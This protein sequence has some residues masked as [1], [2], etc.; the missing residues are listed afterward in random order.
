MKDRSLLTVFLVCLISLS[1]SCASDKTSEKA[2]VYNNRGLAKA[3]SGEYEAA[4][5]AYSAA[6]L[7]NPNYAKAYNNRGV[8]K[9]RL[10]RY[11]AAIADMTLQYAWVLTWESPTT[12]VGP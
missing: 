3:K 5:E 11:E 8:A 1:I 9:K 2:Q 7:L 10:G 4:I 6:I 12:T